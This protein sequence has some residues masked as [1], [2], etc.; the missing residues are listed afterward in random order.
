MTLKNLIENL[1]SRKTF[2][3]GGAKIPII[4]I[5]YAPVASLESVSGSM[6]L[7]KV[8]NQYECYGFHEKFR[9]VLNLL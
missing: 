7:Y 3:G 6:K 9:T 2:Q 8:D 5:I 4:W 1:K